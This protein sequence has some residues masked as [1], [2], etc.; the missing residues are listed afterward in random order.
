[1]D[2]IIICPNCS[3]ELPFTGWLIP[4]N[5]TCLFCDRE[6]EQIREE[7]RKLNNMEV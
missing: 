3:R 1:M 2:E 7:H 6:I 4:E 5:G